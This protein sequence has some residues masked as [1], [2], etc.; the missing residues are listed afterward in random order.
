MADDPARERKAE[1]P[2]G[3]AGDDRGV[4]VGR[5]AS[6][7]A[8]VTGDHNNVKV[9]VYQA[10]AERR[11]PEEPASEEISRNPYM[12]LLAFH[13][14]DADRFFGRE[15]QTVRLWE[16]LRDLQ[17]HHS[18]KPSTR[19]LPILGPSGSGKSSLARA[20]LIPE[21]A[22][23]PLPGWKDA[24]VA[25]LT[26]GSHP[27]EALAGVLARIATGDPA[28]VE[29]TEEFERVLKR[30][31][32]D[33]QHEGLRR[34]A[35]ALPEIATVPLL[36][37]VDQFEEIYSLC[38]DKTQRT[39]FIE[40]LL[41]AVCDRSGRVLVVLTLRNDFLDK[42]QTHESFHGVICT[43]AV[44]IPAMNEQELRAAVAKPAEMAGKPLAPGTVELLVKDTK[45]H[46]GTLPLM[47]FALTKIWDGFAKGKEA[48]ETYREIGGVGGTLAG[49]AQ[50]IYD[51]LNDEERRIAKRVFLGLVQLGEGTRD[52]RRRVAVHQL[53]AAGEDAGKVERVIACFAHRNAR[54]ITLSSVGETAQRRVTKT[55]E[56]THEALFDDWDLLRD[57]IDENR[58][59]L[60]F[61]Q[62]LGEAVLEW[63][64]NGRDESYLYVGQRL[65]RALEWSQH[66]ASELNDAQLAFLEASSAT[67]LVRRL[68]ETQQPQ[69]ILDELSKKSEYALPAI[70]NLLANADYNSP[71]R[72]V[73]QGT[74]IAQ[75]LLEHGSIEPLAG[76]LRHTRW[77]DLRT[78][79]IHTLPKLGATPDMVMEQLDGEREI[80]VRRAL[81]LSLAEFPADRF[82][83][84]EI[85]AAVDRL[86]QLY[87]HDVDPGIHA[88]AEFTLR[89]FDHADD[90][91]AIG[92]RLAT[93]RVDTNRRW[94]VTGQAQC[95]MVIDDEGELDHLPRGARLAIASKLV[96]VDQF[97][98][99][100]AEQDYAHKY[101]P[102]RTAP[103]SISWYDAAAYCNW[104]SVQERIPDHQWCYLPNGE[105]IFAAGMAIAPDFHRRSGY[106]LPTEQEWEYACRA[107]S[108]KL[109]CFGDSEEMLENY[110]CYDKNSNNKMF[111]VGTLKPND[112]G[113]FDMHG[114]VWEWCHDEYRPEH[115]TNERVD[116]L[117]VTSAESRVLRG[118]SFTDSALHVRSAYRSGNHPVDRVGVVGFRVARTY[119]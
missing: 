62:R 55:A 20:G 37:L 70:A 24:R 45:D 90:C 98:R 28:P 107:G 77:P 31:S 29:K 42:T 22:R 43:E 38:N 83:Q 9:V 88:A 18:D 91:R 61:R 15:K 46:E 39:V 2:A 51:G 113:L 63:E 36:V 103:M 72:G 73:E 115:T 75:W 7:N 32:D 95:I 53:V 41:H 12:G 30:K 58:E 111:P 71:L 94:Y 16:K 84:P 85:Q 35:D 76:L 79:L 117:T 19:L 5:D 21:L 8:F 68:P 116:D 119:P 87:E 54:L 114:N 33:G 44:I 93:G 106:R 67:Q 60:K 64:A 65:S 40:N 97:L 100:R 57:W 80:S 89:R 105:G 112:F 108:E 50:R 110:A 92:S 104:L 11:E 23:R 17:S 4:S 109:Y 52:T 69:E 26:P 13:E 3:Q 74:A 25:V 48:A 102:E 86:V 34:I 49:E 78:E 118:G 56:V 47:Q 6:G 99:F 101:T 66:N 1:V 59:S 14:E 82:S 10:V 96:T 81:I 27:L